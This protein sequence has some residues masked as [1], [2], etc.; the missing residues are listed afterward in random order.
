MVVS[1]VSTVGGMRLLSASVA[2]GCVLD[3]QWYDTAGD[4]FTYLVL[5]SLAI[6]VVHQIE[7]SYANVIK[8]GV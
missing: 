7:A 1:T 2:T 4:Y 6:G 5:Q 3:L 8:S